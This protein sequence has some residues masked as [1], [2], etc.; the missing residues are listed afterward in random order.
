MLCILYKYKYSIDDDIILCC[1]INIY[2][3]T[4]TVI[5]IYAVILLLFTR[6]HGILFA[7]TSNEFFS[8]LYIQKKKNKSGYI[9]QKFSKDFNLSRGFI[10][11][12]KAGQ[13]DF[14]I[15]IIYKI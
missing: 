5:E 8:V 6:T 12:T 7:S 1:F 11:S 14:Y 3:L 15:I 4:D 10:Y 13:E 9:W 2:S